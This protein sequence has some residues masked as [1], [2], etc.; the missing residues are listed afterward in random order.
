MVGQISGTVQSS[1]IITANPAPVLQKRALPKIFLNFGATLG[2]PPGLYQQKRPLPSALEAT[3]PE[4][5]R[6]LIERCLENDSKAQFHLYR[7]Y[8]D[9]MYNVCVRMMKKEEDAQDV[10]QEAFVDAFTKLHTYRYDASFGAWLKKVVVN[11]CINA[12]QKRKVPLLFADEAKLDRWHEEEEDHSYIEY[13]V[14]HVRHAIDKLP[15]GCRVVL[16][17]YL[18]EGYDHA[19]IA[20]ILAITEST[21][22]AQ[23]SKA[24]KKLRDLVAQQKQTIWKTL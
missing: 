13:E 18:F 1:V 3:Q 8:A 5:Q 19:E 9:A 4:L 16:N 2:R 17:L 11:K 12:L 20:D 10:L 21:S 24:K 23:Y 15:E 7:L 14:K 6:Y 22:K